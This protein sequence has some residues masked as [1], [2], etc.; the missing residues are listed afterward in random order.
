MPPT[1]KKNRKAAP[2]A[3]REKT[4]KTESG[5][6]KNLDPAI[7]AALYYGFTP[8][9][10]PPITKTDLKRAREIGESDARF[11]ENA[12]WQ[13]E[14]CLPEK[15]ALI[16][17]S[18][19]KKSDCLSEP[20][21]LSFSK[22]ASSDGSGKKSGERRRLVSLEV[23]GSEKSIA[24]VLLIK[25]SLSILAEEGFSELSVYINS[26]GDRESLTRFSRELAAY[27]RRNLE[28]LPAHCREVFKRDAFELLHCRN[29][30]C[31]AIKE[32]APKSMNFLSELSRSQLKEVL[33]YL[34]ILKIPYEIDHFLVGSRGFSCQTIFEIR[35]NANIGNGEEQPPL[36]RGYRYGNIARKLGS[37]K[38]L[39]GIG[40]RLSFRES[41]PRKSSRMERPKIYF[42]QLGF[43][44]KLKSLEVI[45][46]LRR[47]KI[48]VSQ[49]LTR[50][51]LISQLSMAENLKI[52]CA[53]IMGQKE[54]LEESVI[55]RDMENR[56]QETV[57]IR[58]L[59]KC[60]KKF[61]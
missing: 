40:V 13:T 38:D 54:A 52:P 7:G 60:L 47:A 29:E 42:I 55:V 8:I 12:E 23:L 45:E 49:A 1:L 20:L 28:D 9:D 5:W 59:A 36:A 37:K 32:G 31:R 44:A 17:F 34:E 26:I 27:Y 19:E 41:R 53:V 58:D 57:S 4:E 51:K 11:R 25:T 18:E 61:S 39:P 3:P 2:N 16:R 22:I 10:P 6:H 35:Q 24:E 30:K 50:D 15:V 46:T 14:F 48:P 56:S 43:E 33:E 21:L